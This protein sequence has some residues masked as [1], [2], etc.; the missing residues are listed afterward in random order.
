MEK[1]QTGDHARRRDG[2]PITIS[3]QMH[4]PDHLLLV[5]SNLHRCAETI[6]T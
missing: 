2:T 5:Y 6:N 4:N 1:I 3:R